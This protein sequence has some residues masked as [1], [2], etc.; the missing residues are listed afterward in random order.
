MISNDSTQSSLARWDADVT[1]STS[2]GVHSTDV[3]AADEGSFQF[4]SDL[5]VNGTFFNSGFTSMANATFGAL[6]VMQQKQRPQLAQASPE[7]AG[8]SLGS[9]PWSPPKLAA[10]V[11][12]FDQ[13]TRALTP[14]RLGNSASQHCAVLAMGIIRAFPQMMLRR[15][16]FP[17]FIH[18]QWHRSAMPE[19]IA[20][21]MSIAQIFTARTSETRGFLWRT[22]AAEMRRFRDQVG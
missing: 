21:C 14:L 8:L 18:G 4:V 1:L 16:T 19:E 17:P 9:V 2:L 13:N 5:D 15:Q 12:Y 20:N 10:T 7:T 6:D 3:L 11:P 22:I